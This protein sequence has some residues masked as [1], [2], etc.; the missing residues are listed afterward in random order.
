MVAVRQRLN[1]EKWVDRTQHQVQQTH[2]SKQTG[3]VATVDD[4]CIFLLTIV[5]LTR[6]K[7]SKDMIARDERII[8]DQEKGGPIVPLPGYG[9]EQSGA[10]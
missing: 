3:K 10:C 6:S 9:A 1:F 7:I 5:R 8:R 2:R 4:R